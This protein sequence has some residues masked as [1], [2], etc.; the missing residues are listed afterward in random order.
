MHKIKLIRFIPNARDAAASPLIAVAA[1][2]KKRASLLELSQKSSGVAARLSAGWL[3]TSFVIAYLTFK[4]A[5]KFVNT[6]IPKFISIYLAKI[7]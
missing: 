6:I 2:G 1:I 3:T 7:F 4:P 5:R